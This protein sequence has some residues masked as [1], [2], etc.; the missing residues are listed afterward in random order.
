M[1]PLSPPVKD[2]LETVYKSYR[3]EAV[4]IET[5]MLDIVPLGSQML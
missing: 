3:H 5:V 4:V 2:D 1:L